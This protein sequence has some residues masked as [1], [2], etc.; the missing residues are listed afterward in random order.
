MDIMENV[1]NDLDTFI[2]DDL[3]ITN[4]LSLIMDTDIDKYN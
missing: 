3:K 2:N 4:L 1:K